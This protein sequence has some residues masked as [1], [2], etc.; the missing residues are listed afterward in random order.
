MQVKLARSSSIKHI[1]GLRHPKHA[2]KSIPEALQYWSHNQDHSHSE[3]VLPTLAYDQL[4]TSAMLLNNTHC[5]D[6]IVSIDFNNAL[7]CV[8]KK[9]HELRP[10]TV[11]RWSLGQLRK[12]NLC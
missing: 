12:L 4:A 9:T 1:R 6:G 7:L 2:S 3:V 10:R 8:L 11:L 5:V